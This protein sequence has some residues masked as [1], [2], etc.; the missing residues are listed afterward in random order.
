MYPNGYTILLENRQYV[1]REDEFDDFDEDGGPLPKR[2]RCTGE[3]QDVDI[4]GAGDA[5]TTTSCHAGAGVGGDDGA[6]AGAGASAGAGAGAGAGGAQLPGGGSQLDTAGSTA[7]ASDSDD[8]ADKL[9][10]AKRAWEAFV[11]SGDNGMSAP[12]PDHVH[13]AHLSAWQLKR[14]GPGGDGALKWLPPSVEP[15]TDETVRKRARP[16]VWPLRNKA[17]PPVGNL[18][19]QR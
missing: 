4:V 12:L 19:A 14:H 8:N 7:D 9:A 3:G 6:G 1:E 11:R 10:E 16:L 18:S 5:D 15:R 13:D 2:P 17:G